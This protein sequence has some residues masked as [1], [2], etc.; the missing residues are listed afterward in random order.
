TANKR[1]PNELFEQI[2]VEV[3]VVGPPHHALARTRCEKERSF[4]FEIELLNLVEHD[5]AVRDRPGGPERECLRLERDDGRMQAGQLSYAR[6]S[7]ARSIDNKPA[8]N[9]SAVGEMDAAHPSIRPSLEACHFEG[10]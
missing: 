5:W 8:R 6:G 1:W 3:K 10:N 4:R 2:S 9:R 7:C